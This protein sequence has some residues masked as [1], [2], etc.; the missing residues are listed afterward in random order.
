MGGVPE[1]EAAAAAAGRVGVCVCERR[2]KVGGCHTRTHAK[3]VFRI[4]DKTRLKA[5]H[6]S[7]KL[8]VLD[9]YDYVVAGFVPTEKPALVKSSQ[10][11]DAMTQLVEAFFRR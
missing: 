5:P 9:W 10:R 4:G 3:I 8:A 1:E 11:A 7:P 2:N 6:F